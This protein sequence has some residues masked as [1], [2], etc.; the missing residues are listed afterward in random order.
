MKVSA[1]KLTALLEQP[2][3]FPGL[4]AFNRNQAVLF[5]GGDLP[6]QPTLEALFA[7]DCENPVELFHFT[8]STPSCFIN[9][10][11]L[12]HQI[13]K[14][15][16]GYRMGRFLYTPS[17]DHIDAAYAAGLELI[18][19]PFLSSASQDEAAGFRASLQHARS[20]FARWAI[21]TSLTQETPGPENHRTIEELLGS[22]IIPVLQLP[23]A[24]AGQTEAWLA[25]YQSLVQQWRRSKAYLKPIMPLLLLCT[26]LLAEPPRTGME[27]LLE[28]ANEASQR[29]TADLRRLLRVRGAEQ[30]FDSAGL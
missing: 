15:F 25:L 2:V 5:L 30:S 20:L 11:P 24:A 9:A 23:A 12:A 8:F 3:G 28:V 14:N 17:L 16:K 7:S 22:G 21:V 4:G 29:A 6:L 19:L 27:R 13:Q 10:L 26:P 18:D 1:R